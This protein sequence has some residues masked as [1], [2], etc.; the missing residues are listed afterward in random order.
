MMKDPAGNVVLNT[1]YTFELD[2]EAPVLSVGLDNSTN[3]DSQNDFITNNDTLSFS[4]TAENNST[5]LIRDKA[6]GEVLTELVVGDLGT[7]TLTIENVPDGVHTYLV[8]LKDEAGNIST[9]EMAVTV[10]T[11]QPVL[12]D[13]GILDSDNTVVEDD[14][15]TSNNDITI[16]GQ[17]GVNETVQ[18]TI[19]PDGAVVQ[20]DVDAQG[21]FT[22]QLPALEKGDYSL[23]IV[24]MDAAGNQITQTQ[25][26]TITADEPIPEAEIMANTIDDLN[27]FTIDTLPPE[28]FVNNGF[29][30]SGEVGDKD[31]IEL[32]L[33]SENTSEELTF[34]ADIINGKWTVSANPIPDGQYTWKV[35]AT[36]SQN[37]IVEKTG[38]TT[39]L[40]VSETLDT[41]QADLIEPLSEDGILSEFPTFSGIVPENA[42]VFIDITNQDTQE[43]FQIS[44]VA[45]MDGG[46]SMP[47]PG[48]EEGNYQ[49][50]ASIVNETGQLEKIEESQFTLDKSYAPVDELD[51]V[52]NNE[53]E[54]D[55]TETKVFSGQSEPETSVVLNIADKE[56]QTESDDDGD[57][58]IKAEF[59]KPGEYDYQL[60]YQTKDNQ[61][62]VENGKVKVNTLSIEV[63]SD[64]EGV[65]E[66]Q[67][68][69]TNSS[70]PNSAS[71]VQIMPD[72]FDLPND[73]DY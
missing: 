59:E 52:L 33:L 68:D 23:N 26:L 20:G 69:A 16:V 70:E 13:V 53:S 38:T 50:T 2:Y 6:T 45:D 60:S 39:L 22:A 1:T 62:A 46:W 37:Q 19:A 65:S 24:A 3:T 63:S 31:N 11:N 51:V 36:N 28:S 40:P 10:D 44:T 5:V 14:W 21:R 17:V 9:K 72:N 67:N 64:E 49:W 30:L 34:S 58:T 27:D 47:M 25:A 71:Q 55:I 12:T 4:G 66:R 57:W 29:D 42:A 35:V 61:T 56:Y 43:T 41:Q 54:S 15:S 18:I 73:H 32:I 48:L 8:E 7:F